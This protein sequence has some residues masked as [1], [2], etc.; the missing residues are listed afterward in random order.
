MSESA[1]NF[2]NNCYRDC[3]STYKSCMSRK[4][5]ESVCKMKHAQ[6]SCGCVLDY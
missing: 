5:D 2:D 3:E 4:E 1:K 6:C